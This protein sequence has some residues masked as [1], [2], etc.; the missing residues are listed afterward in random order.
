MS[1]RAAAGGR[2]AAAR[3]G[4]TSI[5]IV[6]YTSLAAVA[7]FLIFVAVSV[8]PGD[9]ASQQLGLG[10]SPT[11]LERLRHQMGLDQPVLLRFLRWVGGAVKGDWGESAATGAAVS[12][13]LV[14]PVARSG[15]LSLL[16]LCGIAVFGVGG[17]I[18]AGATQKRW[19]DRTLSASALS[20]ICTPEFVVGTALVFVFSTAMGWLPAVSL[21]PAGGHILD[22]PESLILPALTITLVGGG[23]LLRQVRAIVEAQSQQAHVE[24]AELAG[25]RRAHVVGNHVL[26]GALPAIAQSIALVV[27][28]V[29]GG[30]V[31]VERVFGFPGLGSVLVNAV[32]NRDVAVLMGAALIIVIISVS[33]YAL[34]DQVGR[35]SG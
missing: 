21:V 32:M 19:V 22:R 12:A 31:V 28:Y 33:A 3:L 17:G 29:V 14:G 11:A 8:L 13:L 18:V 6:R 5:E 30:T 24:S 23:A 10:A 26:P 25:L 9:A 20:A 4:R 1:P 15:I 34:A 16:V 2:T 35:R 7:L 27:P